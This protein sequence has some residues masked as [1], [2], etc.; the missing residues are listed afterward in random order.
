MCQ[1]CVEH[2]E[3]ERWYLQAKNY[4][5]DLLSDARRREYMVGFIAGFG[6]SRANAIGW[7]ERLEHI[8]APLAAAGKSIASRRMRDHHFGQPLPIEDCERVL[9]LATSITVIPCICRMHTPGKHAEPVCVLVTTAPVEPILADGFKDYEDGPE[10]D[11]FHSLTKA[12]AMGLLRSC[13]ERGLMHSV[14]TFQTPFTAA[15][16]N[17]DLESGCMAMKLTAGYE[18]KLMWRGEYIALADAERCISCGA[19]EPACPFSAIERTTT[20]P[21]EP[22]A[23]KCWGCGV[24]RAHCPE[25]AISLIDRRQVPEVATLW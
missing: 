17:C 15:I 13:E 10:L 3:G 22:V 18:M 5:A 14:W 21:Y 11:D 6:A 25:D 19:C 16:C 24:C 2:G 9:D 23:K 4:S 12:E 20:G 7:M 1:F 8:P